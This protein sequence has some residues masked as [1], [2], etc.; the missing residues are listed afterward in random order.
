LSA[1]EYRT[2]QRATMLNT[3]TNRHAERDHP[4]VSSTFAYIAVGGWAV[5]LVALVVTWIIHGEIHARNRPPHKYGYVSRLHGKGDK[6]YPTLLLQIGCSTPLLFLVYGG[7]GIGIS[8][9]FFEGSLNTFVITICFIASGVWIISSVA[10]HL[11]NY[12]SI[13]QM[14]VYPTSMEQAKKH[15]N[16]VTASFLSLGEGS[17]FTLIPGFLP[18]G[19]LINHLREYRLVHKSQA[20]KQAATAGYPP[21]WN[22]LRHQVYTRDNHTCQ[23]C[24]ATS[25]ELHAHHVVPLSAGGT[26]NTSNL[27]TL[28][29]SCHTKVH[30]RMRDG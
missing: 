22:E 9:Y 4:K 13:K 28:C 7:L 2:N 5:F 14:N 11:K 23:N 18:V 10:F 30:P 29:A 21:N 6:F 24:G 20:K 16:V 27:T 19:L 17:F 1:N 8:E 26:N 3:I 25:V 12:Q 15:T